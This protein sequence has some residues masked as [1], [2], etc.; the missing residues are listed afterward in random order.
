MAK[1]DTYLFFNGN[2]AEAMRFYEKVLGGKLQALMQYK[3]GPPGACAAGAEDRVMHAALVVGDR[4]LMASDTVPQFGHDGNKGFAVALNF[5]TVPEAKRAFEA[6]A[7]GGKIE[8]PFDKAFFME[9]F[10]MLTDRFGIP[11]MIGG[12]AA[13]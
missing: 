13:K 1:I 11:W 10:G 8:M 9:A 12:G 3:D 2:C 6:L 5:A 7:E 4:M